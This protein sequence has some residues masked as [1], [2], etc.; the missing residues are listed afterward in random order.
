MCHRWCTFVVAQIRPPLK[1]FLSFAWL[2]L[3]VWFAGCQVE[4]DS[5]SPTGDISVSVIDQRGAPVAGARVFTDPIGRIEDITDAFGSATVKDVA[6]GTYDVFAE[7]NGVQAKRAVNV[8]PGNLTSAILQLPIVLP[9]GGNT[10]GSP[11]LFLT[12]PQQ[13]G[14]Y[15][16]GEGIL[17]DAT[18]SDDNSTGKQITIRWTSNLDGLLGEGTGD[19]NG[20]L[21]FVKTLSPGFHQLTATA[22]DIDG[23]TTTLLLGVNVAG[24]ATIRLAAVDVSAAE[25]RLSWSRYL[26]REFQRY[27]VQ[28][29]LGDCAAPGFS[30]WQT[31]ATLNSVTDTSY[32]D[33]GSQPIAANICYRI[34]VDAP[35]NAAAAT[36]NV[37]SY[38]PATTDLLDFVPSDMVAHPT[39]ANIVFLVDGAGERVLR[40]DVSTRAVSAV[41]T[42]SGKLGE[43]AVGDAGIGSELFVPSGNGNVY[44]LNLATLATTRLINTIDPVGSV[45]VYE[46]GFIVVASTVPLVRP[47]QY[48][49]YSRTTG[50]LLASNPQSRGPGAIRRVP[51]QRSAVALSTTSLVAEPAYFEFD[52]VGQFTFAGNGVLQR[53]N[54][55]SSDIFAV[56]P[57]GTYF[58]TSRL[59]NSFDVSR[60]LTFR[61][62]LDYGTL[63]V[64]DIAFSAGGDLVYGAV[65]PPVDA[66]AADAPGIIVARWPSRLRERFIPTRGYVTQVA[67][68]AD[69]R[70]ATVQVARTALPANAGSAGGLSLVSVVQ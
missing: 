62:R 36:S 26:G 6:V 38:A 12:A 50:A 13:T 1:P 4:D 14:T 58:V 63:R 17:F 2:L 69:G 30:D 11:R 46:D 18:A 27:R 70:L 19:A 33:A 7:L 61:G 34:V 47:G 9:A 32:V 65:A 15:Q 48:R 57:T 43:L 5:L 37:V 23:N 54:E 68:L 60:Q 56:D 10:D 21:T 53:D 66:G 24:V 29:G 64:V 51:G 31:I 16:A 20:R 40:Y 41:A 45:A 49:V 25:A 28:R 8:G 52:P 22:T 3:I 42:L 59:A 67:R 35:G 39:D 55:Q 44:V